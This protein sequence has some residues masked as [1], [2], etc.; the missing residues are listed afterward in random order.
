MT[1][2]T[3]KTYVLFILSIGTL[4]A[5]KKS[6]AGGN[7]NPGGGTPPSDTIHIAKGA[8]ISWLTQMEAAGIKFYDSTGTQKDCYQILKGTWNEFH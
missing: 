3:G 2:M 4:L 1:N 8:D 7:T 5:C 6:P